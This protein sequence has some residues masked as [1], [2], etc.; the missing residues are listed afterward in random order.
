MFSRRRVLAMSGVAA[1]SLAMPAIVRAA[2][3][4]II[5]SHA[6][7]ESHPGHIG[8]MAFKEAAE[9]LLPGLVEVQVF[10][11]RQLGD[12]KQN[13]ESAVAGTVQIA[14]V[15]SVM[16]PL[17]T[18]RTGLDALQLPFL[19]RDYDHFGTLAK[20]PEMQAILDDLDAAGL[21]GL[22][23]AD[24]GQRHFLSTK[25]PVT[26]LPEFQGIKTRIV[27][28]PLHQEIWETVG[29]APVGLPYGEV[30]GALETGVLD[31]VETNVSS[32]VGEN[33]WEV[34]KHFTLTGHYPWP[35]VIMANKAWFDG[36]P[37]EIQDGLREAGRQM[38]E[39]T[40]AYAKDQDMSARE[41]LKAKGVQIH[42]LKDLADMKAKV[43]P[44]IEEW[45]GKSPLIKNFVDAAQKS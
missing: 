3:V 9:R 2:P 39:P 26:S 19:I 27:P 34:G 42:E 45:S 4:S 16:V 15:S 35:F 38:I 33:L 43:N 24:I 44:I 1:A 8:S 37:K 32:I 6:T 29:A 12:D 17:V 22:G 13:A 14:G 7:A 11:N 23:V 20:T 31:G 5:M 41:D 28:V 18:G 30:Y 10:G 40:L 25:T 21:V 36:L